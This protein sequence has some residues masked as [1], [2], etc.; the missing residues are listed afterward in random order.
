MTISLIYL[1]VS[2]LIAQTQAFDGIE[3]HYSV[4]ANQ[5]ESHRAAITLVNTGSDDIDTGSQ[6]LNVYPCFIR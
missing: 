6:A 2:S 3:V 4:L 1:V 5:G